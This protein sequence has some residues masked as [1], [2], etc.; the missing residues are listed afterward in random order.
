MTWPDYRRNSR[1]CPRPAR[2]V[3][4]QVNLKAHTPAFRAHQPRRGPRQGGLLKRPHLSAQ[5][6]A[7]RLETIAGRLGTIEFSVPEAQDYLGEAQLPQS[8]KPER[9]TP[10]SLKPKP[11]TGRDERVPTDLQAT[12]ESPEIQ[13]RTPQRRNPKPHSLTPKPLQTP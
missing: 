11:E 2:C 13:A 5:T 4:L 12:L 6:V 8:L 3:G 9:R 1:T 7:G 10:Q